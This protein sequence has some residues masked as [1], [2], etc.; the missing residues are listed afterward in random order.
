MNLKLKHMTLTC[1][2]THSMVF[3]AINLCLFKDV[4]LKNKIHH[5]SFIGD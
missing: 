5:G 1:S 3:S 4:S 2:M